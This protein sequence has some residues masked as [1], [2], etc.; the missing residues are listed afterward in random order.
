MKVSKKAAATRALEVYCLLLALNSCF[1]NNGTQMV[2]SGALIHNNFVQTDLSHKFVL[3][4][5]IFTEKN[6]KYR[7]TFLQKILKQITPLLLKVTKK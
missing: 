2:K 1:E 6:L 7:P 3:R 4:V 5:R